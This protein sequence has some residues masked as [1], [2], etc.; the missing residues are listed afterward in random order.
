MSRIE[1]VIFDFD[2]TLVDTAPDIVRATNNYLTSKGFEPLSEARIR[3]EIGMGL[4]RLLTD[5]YPDKNL[6]EKKQTEIYTQFTES[7]EKEFLKTPVL[8]DG[9]EEFLHS[10]DRS[11]AIVSNKRSRFITPILEQLN[12][13]H[14]PWVDI[15][16]GDTLPKMKPHPEP[17]LRAMHR[18]G[19]T[20]EQTLIVGDGIPDVEGA[21]NVGSLC[22]AVEFGY[23]P[24]D[25]LM[26][27]G[28]WKTLRS[29]NDLKGLI[30][31][32][33]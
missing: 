26:Q 31:S 11:I 30:A 27:L 12:I 1:L 8:Y 6:S 23:T 17:F 32:I 5:I 14:L 9:A 24:S 16:G 19:V 22:A 29:F 33:T 2:G 10:W 18:A 13:L 15:V 7:Y 3:S 28:A 20:P 25:F 21:K 4:K